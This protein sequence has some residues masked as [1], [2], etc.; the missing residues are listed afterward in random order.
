MI[1]RHY[2]SDEDDSEIFYHEYTQVTTT[3]DEDVIVDNN[4]EQV[5]NIEQIEH[6]KKSHPPA[7][8]N[9]PSDMEV[10]TKAPACIA[11][12]FETHQEPKVSSLDCLQEP[13][14]AKILKDLCKQVQKSRNHFPKKILRSKQFYIR[15]RNTLPEGYKVLKKKG[16]KGLIGHQYD[17]GKRCVLVSKFGRL[18]SFF[19]PLR[20]LTSGNV[21]L[22]YTLRAMCNSS[23]GVWKTLCLFIFVFVIII[24]IFCPFVQK[25]NCAIF[26]S[27]LS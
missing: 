22:Y 27:S 24:I 7:D 23:L 4:E 18:P 13:S 25:K 21:L 20:F 12:P 5:E 19:T 16:W 2:M 15:W 8:P 10:S 6:H 1:E 9:L 26:L 14:Y 17:R 11:V 3:L